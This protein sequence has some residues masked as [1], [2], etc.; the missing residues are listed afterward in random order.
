MLFYSFRCWLFIY[1][2]HLTYILALNTFFLYVFLFSS[3]F[4]LLVCCLCAAAA[5]AAHS[6]DQRE[7]KKQ[8]K[9]LYIFF[10]HKF[11]L[12]AFDFISFSLHHL[13]RRTGLHSCGVRSK[14]IKKTLSII[15]NAAEK[16]LLLFVC[17]SF[18]RFVFDVANFLGLMHSLGFSFRV[19]TLRICLARGSAIH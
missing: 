19:L 3:R 9:I 11:C 13:L 6:N 2:Y 7:K 4:S 15:I 10:L 12:F 1:V 5:A 8:H 14:S 17:C 16:L 18:F